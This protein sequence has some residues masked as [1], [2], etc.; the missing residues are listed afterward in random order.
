MYISHQI[1]IQLTQI[2]SS[3]KPKW[4]KH[5]KNNKLGLNSRQH[6]YQILI[7][8][9][10]V[11]SYFITTVPVVQKRM[12]KMFFTFDWLLNSFY[13]KNVIW[14][15]R[16]DIIFQEMFLE[17]LYVHHWLNRISDEFTGNWVYNNNILV[18]ANQ[19]ST[20]STYFY[21]EKGHL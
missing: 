6:T 8:N 18:P 5:W 13:H 4:Y 2:I 21:E 14:L 1:M 20:F 19:V 9:D 10:F 11:V 17:I 3:S 16:P 7:N 12:T 15:K